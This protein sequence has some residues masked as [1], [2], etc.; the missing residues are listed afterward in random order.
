MMLLLTTVLTP[1]G[2]S[3]PLNTTTTIQALNGITATITA[4]LATTAL[5]LLLVGSL[6]MTQVGWGA[7]AYQDGMQK[8]RVALGTVIAAALM[9]TLTNVLLSRN[10]RLGQ[11]TAGQ[12]LTTMPLVTLAHIAG[13]LLT[14][15]AP[16]ALLA[17]I[18]GAL[19]HTQLFHSPEAKAQG[20][21]IL[22]S[23][24]LALIIAVLA[25]SL[26]QMLIAL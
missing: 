13:T 4:L 12:P 1:F 23:A 20:Q 21:R 18:Y 16:A 7:N 2:L 6:Q 22:R 8:I 9:S 10:P 19:V 11:A 3:S 26:I 15:V 25:Q 14:L 5:I 24:A 17:M